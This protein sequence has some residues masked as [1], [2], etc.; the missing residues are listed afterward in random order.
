[1]DA[2]LVLNA[3]SS[4]L[5]F[6][7]FDAGADRA[8]R[9]I[10]RGRIARC[11]DGVEWRVIDDDGEVI[12][13]SID[14]ERTGPFSLDAALAV[15]LGWLGAQPSNLSIRAIGH[16]VVHGGE[17]HHAPAVITD[18]LHDALA[19]LVSMA[20][21]HQPHSLQA[22][23]QSRR[24]WPDAAQVACFDT[25]FHRT[26]PAVAQ[27]FALPRELTESGIRRYGFHGLSFDYIASRLDSV[28]GPRGRG[29]VI[30]AHLGN[31]ASLCAMVD[32]R[33]VAATTGFSTLDG[34]VMGTRCGNLDPG[35]VLHLQ[36]E[37]GLS[38]EAVS[39][40]LYH[41][42]G[43]LG[44]S[45][46]SGDMRTLLGLMAAGDAH[47]A[48]A[49]ELYVY[50]IVCEIGSLAAAMGG[51]DALVFTGGV[52]EN[53]APIRER[54]A[55]GCAWLGAA[56]DTTANRADLDLIHAKA[57]RVAMAVIPTDEESVIATQ[58]L[59]LLAAMNGLSAG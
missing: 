42:S 35:V 12:S 1:M 57:S 28:L 52:G 45:G 54:V 43:L 39:E 11:A 5:K 37:R 53:A 27:A 7:S 32:G 51:L 20:P 24:L 3:G 15:L 26:Q 23:R 4:S 9:P 14:T 38:V 30:V 8:A 17:Q 55:A 22:I 44:V 58:T 56:I 50:R 21:L 18:E 40:M 19:Q 48:E 16:R 2:V 6:A 36:Q 59:Q 13:Q 49:I 46:S 47:A 25:A 33:S 34:L 31:G 10:W 41:R 29:K